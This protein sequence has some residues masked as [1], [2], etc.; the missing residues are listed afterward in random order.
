MS[1]ISCVDNPAIINVNQDIV[2]LSTPQTITAYKTFASPIIS[3]TPATLANQVINFGQLE[4]LLVKD[5]VL[6]QIIGGPIIF[7]VAPVCL[8]AP[9]G[10]DNL[11]TLGFANANYVKQNTSSTIPAGTVLTFTDPPICATAATTP[12]ELV[13]KAYVDALPTNQGTLVSNLLIDI[14]AIA[15][16]ST[17]ANF[18]PAACSPTEAGTYLL[19]ICPQIIG[20]N[21]TTLQQEGSMASANIIVTNGI[22]NIATGG[23]QCATGITTSQ[24]VVPVAFSTDGTAV[25]HAIC[26]GYTVTG[27]AGDW[28]FDTTGGASTFQ[29]IKISDLVQ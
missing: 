16:G 7:D 21:A 8:A 10:I 5:T 9:A 23:F 2:T 22:N 15:S 29:L 1:F 13:N 25:I 28:T 18:L 3:P 14:G 11:I 4:N 19:N 20:Y 27:T 26:T 6:G 12:T 24:T 17:S